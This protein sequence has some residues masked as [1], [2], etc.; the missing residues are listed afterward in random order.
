M[1]TPTRQ[2]NVEHVLDR[3]QAVVDR[4]NRSNRRLR[5]R[6]IRDEFAVVDEWTNVVVQPEKPGARALTYLDALEKIQAA[7]ESDGIEGVM[8]VPTYA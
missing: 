8:V 5:L 7:L 2:A 6:L 3:V 1:L 4:W